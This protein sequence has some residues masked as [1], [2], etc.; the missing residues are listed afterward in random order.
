MPDRKPLIRRYAQTI[1]VKDPLGGT[2]EVYTRLTKKEYVSRRAIFEDPDYRD[3]PSHLSSYSYDEWVAWG[4]QGGRPRKW[5][6]EAERKRAIRAQQKLNHGQP[7]TSQERALLGLIKKRPGAYKSGLGRP[8]T[9]AERKRA[10]RA[11]QKGGNN[12]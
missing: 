3:T 5:I 4:G 6:N 8:L 9:P 11:R 10:Q 2:E 12:M 1:R 7:L